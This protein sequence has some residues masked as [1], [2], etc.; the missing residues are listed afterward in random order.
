MT[1]KK[2]KKS[3]KSKVRKQVFFDIETDTEYINVHEVVSNGNVKVRSD[4]K[5][6]HKE[7]NRN[8]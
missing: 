4:R 5:I 7:A 3:K 6:A 1:R 2:S 8:L